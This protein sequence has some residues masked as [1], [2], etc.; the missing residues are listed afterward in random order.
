[1]NELIFTDPYS[2]SSAVENPFRT[3][4]CETGHRFHPARVSNCWNSGRSDSN[5]PAATSARRKATIVTIL[6]FGVHLSSRMVAASHSRALLG[7]L[8]MIPDRY[9]LPILAHSIAPGTT[10]ALLVNN[11]KYSRSRLRSR[12]ICPLSSRFLL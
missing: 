10:A 12:K 11:H 9:I 4:C 5:S 6:A 2:R 8:V 1:M 7:Q 3:L